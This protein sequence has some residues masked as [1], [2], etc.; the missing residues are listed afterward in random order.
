MQVWFEALTGIIKSKG[1]QTKSV[2]LSS[3][4]LKASALSG[5]Y[6]QKRDSSFFPG[7]R[8]NAIGEERHCSQAGRTRL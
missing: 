1:V 4:A 5:Y 2:S 3:C 6:A 7:E 8:G